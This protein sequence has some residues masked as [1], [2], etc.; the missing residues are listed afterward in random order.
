MAGGAGSNRGTGGMHTKL[1]AAQKAG[2][3]GIDTA[4]INGCKPSLLYDLFDGKA[5]GTRF[6]LGFVPG[7]D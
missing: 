1:L 6:E 5:V 3:A 7:K 4:I 2:S